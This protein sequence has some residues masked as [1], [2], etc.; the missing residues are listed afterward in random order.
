MAFSLIS[1]GIADAS[2]AVSS[3][4]A[5]SATSQATQT[6]DFTSEKLNTGRAQYRNTPYPV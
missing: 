5:V 1:S 3:P 2:A 6:M 4:S